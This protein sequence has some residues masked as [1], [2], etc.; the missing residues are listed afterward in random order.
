MS[1]QKKSKEMPS[2]D[3]AV[4]V[5]KAGVI[6]AYTAG[7]ILLLLGILA[8]FLQF[9]TFKVKPQSS[10]GI[11][12]YFAENDILKNFQAEKEVFRVKVPFDEIN[13]ELIKKALETEENIFNMEFDLKSQIAK[14]NYR[15][16]GFY[17]PVQFA[18]I[19]EQSEAQI[20]YFLKPKALGNLGIPMPQ[21]FLKGLLKMVDSKLGEGI[22][23]PSDSFEKYGWE[24][25]AWH[26][27]DD[28]I[29]TELTLAT[30]KLNELVQEI[31]QM[32]DKQIAFMYETG[33]E[34]QKQLI[35]LINGYP[36]TFDT[37]KKKLV[38][39]YF[40]ENALF[41]D[42]LI[43]MNSPLMHKTF[44]NYPFIRGRL[45]ENELLK[46][47]SDWI[48]SSISFYGQEIL[49]A[50]KSWQET[51]GGLYYNNGYPY[52]KKEGRTVT[53]KEVVET[54]SLPISEN[55]VERIHFGLDMVDNRLAV[56]Y[57]VDVGNYAIIKE[58]GYFVVDE[59]TYV[60]RYKR[61]LPL[62]GE[63]T[64][65]IH[66]WDGIVGKLKESLKTEEI[67]VRYMKNDDK[68]AFVLVS[69]LE[70]PQDVQA[71]TFSKIEGNWLPTASNFKD[72]LELQ[73]H[74]PKFNLNLYTD[75]YEQPKLIYIDENALDNIKEELS[76]AKKL[77]EG[78]SPIYYSYKDKYIYVKLSNGEEYVLTT[79]HQY[80]DKL[81]G[82]EDAIAA[83]GD[84]LPRI[85]LLQP[86]PSVN[87]EE[88]T[89]Q[90]KKDSE[91]ETQ[92]KDT[93]NR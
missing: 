70:K 73:S 88:E 10:K 51:T 35:Q 40:E 87:T 29:V 32:P 72:I 8:S 52:L 25:L 81:F 90:E 57:Q 89:S 42:F 20:S 11:S 65:D 85:I 39:T 93:T 1:M 13:A 16:G 78:V 6:L 64:Q 61:D 31:R 66:V 79:Y 49:K 28:A 9:N 62:Q 23:I 48:A 80:L 53:V 30:E 26:P 41:K 83:Y 38:E 76:F 4:T 45:N 59:P 27:T 34:S 56:I 24:N 60:A 5:K 82:R 91:K 68:N 55:I 47:R 17:L 22:R 15:I 50:A 2:T 92:N 33:T 63:L 3:K 7:A 12:T 67:F 36:E 44:E 21:F 74:D 69:F 77:P 58:E 14:V 19:P 84:A 46:Q 54:W 75:I 37:L 18:M 86:A 71:I 43:L